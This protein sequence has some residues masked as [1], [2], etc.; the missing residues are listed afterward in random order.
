MK[1]GTMGGVGVVEVMTA[2]LPSTSKE[3][4]R[5]VRGDYL[6]FVANGSGTL[7]QVWRNKM[8][9]SVARFDGKV[10]QEGSLS[11]RHLD[12]EGMMIAARALAFAAGLD[13]RSVDHDG[14]TLLEFV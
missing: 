6:R 3:G 5:I 7:M 9:L 13:V 14:E 2:C 4:L 1:G 10:I 8:R 12:D 11:L